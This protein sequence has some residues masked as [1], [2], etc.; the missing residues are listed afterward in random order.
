M[1]NYKYIQDKLNNGKMVILDGAN[2]SELEKRGA[3]MDGAGW[4]G[5]ASITHPKILEDIHKDYITAGAEV[6]T[7]NTFSSARHV[8]EYSTFTDQTVA[9]NEKAMECAVSARNHFPDRKV[10]IAGSLSLSLVADIAD[11]I[12]DPAEFR[13]N[14]KLAQKTREV[15][16]FT[17]E[18]IRE[19]SFNYNK[20]LKNFN[21]QISIFKKYN[22]DLIILEMIINPSICKPAID[23]ALASGMP[24]WLG[25]SCGEE[26]EAG[27]LLA[28]E[29]SKMKYTI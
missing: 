17:E 13:D 6:I 5:P 26:S 29:N 18:S 22:I 4:C 3:Q 8:L 15:T 24:V 23:A 19:G 1:E 20:I 28:F 2:G 25:L 9:I 11:G 14:M 16:E 12:N 27:D 7:T 21:E 10:A